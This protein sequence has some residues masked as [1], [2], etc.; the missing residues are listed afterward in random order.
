MVRANFVPP[1]SPPAADH[2]GLEARLTAVL[3]P[4]LAELERKLDRLHDLLAARRKDQLTVA[5]FA[6][7]VGR[8]AYT[9]RRWIGEGRVRAVRIADGGPKGRLLI[10]RSELDRVIAAAAGGAIPDSATN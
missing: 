6:E 5:E 8:S 9:L 7:A 4:R 2:G 10:A 3:G 1:P